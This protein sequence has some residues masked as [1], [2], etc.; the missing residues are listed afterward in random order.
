[1]T[2]IDE[3]TVHSLVLVHKLRLINKWDV[4]IGQSVNIDMNAIV[5]INAVHG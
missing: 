5:L 2:T 4:P 1:M 3:L